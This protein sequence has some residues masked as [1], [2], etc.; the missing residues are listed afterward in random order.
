M[1]SLLMEAPPVGEPVHAHAHQPHSGHTT[2][3]W[4]TRADVTLFTCG[5]QHN[6]FVYQLWARSAVGHLWSRDEYKNRRTSFSRLADLVSADKYAVSW[7]SSY[8]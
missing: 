5:S 7:T 3:P 8:S 1:C 6:V 2:T 4:T